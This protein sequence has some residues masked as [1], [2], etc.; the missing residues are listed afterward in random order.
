MQETSGKR[1]ERRDFC[2]K[3][4]RTG[5]NDERWEKMRGVDDFEEVSKI[6]RYC[7]I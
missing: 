4:K 5:T 7:L 3:N 1:E 6:M 2:V